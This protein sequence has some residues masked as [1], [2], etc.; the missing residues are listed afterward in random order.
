MEIVRSD[1]VELSWIVRRMNSTEEM[2]S[3]KTE[4]EDL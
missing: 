3:E 1:S 2:V 4:T